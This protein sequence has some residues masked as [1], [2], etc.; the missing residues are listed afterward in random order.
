MRCAA[1]RGPGAAGRGAAGPAAAR[2]RRSV[3][4][5]PERGAHALGGR[6][7]GRLTASSAARLAG[8]WG[9]R[10]EATSPT[11]AL[12]PSPAA[13]VR[14]TDL[15]VL[16]GPRRRLRGSERVEPRGR[17]RPLPR[18]P[19]GSAGSSAF[20]IGGRTGQAPT[21]LA[22]AGTAA[23]ETQAEERGRAVDRGERAAPGPD[24]AGRR[25]PQDGSREGRACAAVTQASAPA[26]LGVRHEALDAV[27]DPLPRTRKG[28]TLSR[29]GE[30]GTWGPAPPRL[31]SS[32]ADPGCE[33]RDASEAPGPK[34]RREGT[35][36]S[37]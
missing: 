2:A 34:K 4:G 10:H 15:A 23:A 27:P 26:G 18:E 7:H 1:E 22:G 24:A 12:Q 6:P 9:E 20:S 37:S 19:P 13:D 25:W 35:W 21:E 31:G 14:S 28:R 32:G 8:G 29:G 33:P 16:A 3:R 5:A 30:S 36:R 11:E 17:P